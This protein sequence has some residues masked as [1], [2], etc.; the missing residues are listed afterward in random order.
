MENPYLTV[1]EATK[2][3]RILNDKVKFMQKAQHGRDEV[4]GASSAGVISGRLAGRCVV[5][6]LVESS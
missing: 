6:V 5:Q 2:V 1:P 4:W 3:W